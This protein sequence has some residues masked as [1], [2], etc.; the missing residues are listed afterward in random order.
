[1][2]LAGIVYIHRIS[3]PRMTGTS[4]RNFKM[5]LDLCGDTTLR[6]VVIAT[7]MWELAPADAAER[8][9]GEM[10][11]KYFEPVI[12][13]GGQLLR[14]YNTDDS[15]RDVLQSII[16]NHPEPLKIQKELVDEHKNIRDTTAGQSLVGETEKR[17][18]E[19]LDQMQAAAEGLFLITI[20]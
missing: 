17:L 20:S 12:R 5:F 16:K 4:V 14:L 18:M 6:N 1:V 7:N 9:E 3:D 2:K 11:S 10:R 13:M 8:R 15:A 19:K